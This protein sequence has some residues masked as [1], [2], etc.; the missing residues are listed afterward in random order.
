M[1]VGLTQERVLT[2]SIVLWVVGLTLIGERTRNE[3]Q[4]GLSAEKVDRPGS[5]VT[6]IM[7]WITKEEEDGE[8]LFLQSAGSL[9]K[10]KHY[11]YIV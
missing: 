2:T 5:T 4:K 11:F 10:K 7:C 3:R 6:T 1:Q 9:K 8:T